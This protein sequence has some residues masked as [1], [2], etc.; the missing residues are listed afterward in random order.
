ML[1]KSRPLDYHPQDKPPGL[2]QNAFPHFIIRP[3]LWHIPYFLATL[4]SCLSFPTPL[5]FFHPFTHLGMFSPDMSHACIIVWCAPNTSN[6]NLPHP[7]TSLLSLP[8]LISVL[9]G[10]IILLTTLLSLPHQLTSLVLASRTL[11]QEIK[12]W[13]ESER[14][15]FL[16]TC[17]RPLPPY[18]FFFSWQWLLSCNC[19]DSSCKA[20]SSPPYWAS[21]TWFPPLAS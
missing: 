12:D 20:P 3:L 18:F 4:S 19:G 5:P 16:M 7:Q 13:E 21:V 14:H 15:W 9:R 1:S 10:Y 2:T 6:E 8:I 11:Q 17:S